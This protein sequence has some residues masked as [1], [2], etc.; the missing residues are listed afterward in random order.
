MQRLNCYSFFQLGTVLKPLEMIEEGK[1]LM[2][3][4]Y[5]IYVARIWLEWFLNDKLVAITFSKNTG[6]NLLSA[7]RQLVHGTVSEIPQEKST[8]SLSGS[9]VYSIRNT[10]REFQIV[11]QTE[12]GKMDT[13]FVSQKGIYSTSDLIEKADNILPPDIL[14]VLPEPIVRDLRQAG[15]CLAFDLPNGRWFS[16]YAC[17]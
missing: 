17:R 1:E 15:R 14:E 10:L 3:V 5:D 9:D 11:L 16:H 4:A 7:L 2:S 12:L 13:Y 8:Y 6:Y